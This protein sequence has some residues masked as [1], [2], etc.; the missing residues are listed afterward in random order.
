MILDI[1]IPDYL[2]CNQY[3]FLQFLNVKRERNCVNRN[4]FTKLITLE[5]ILVHIM[6]YAFQK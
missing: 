2:V 5:L 3:S 1:L 6:M 4:I